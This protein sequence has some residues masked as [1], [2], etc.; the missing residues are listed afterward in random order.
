MADI[1]FPQGILRSPL[2]SSYRRDISRGF[3]ASQPFSGAPY[4][5]R[6][7]FDNPAI[8]DLQ[9]T[10]E[11][12]KNAIFAEWLY[13]DS[14]D[15]LNGGIKPFN[16]ELEVEGGRAVQEAIFTED[17]VPQLTNIRNNIYTYT[18]QVLVRS[19]VR[20]FDGQYD[21]L[22]WFAERSP[23]GDP[24]TGMAILNRAITETAP[25]A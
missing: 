21:F 23:D 16:I 4:R 5:L 6:T 13:A 11:G 7:S 12:G 9:F 1:D 20:P 25:E 15:T 2:L 8:F 10:L 22:K 17:G 18:A 19:L 3:V 24:F 14:A